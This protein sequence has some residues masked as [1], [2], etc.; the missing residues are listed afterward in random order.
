MSTQIRRSH[1][2]R[3]TRWVVWMPLVLV[4][5]LFYWTIALG[6]GGLSLLAVSAL[7]AGGR[8]ALE[9]GGTA[10]EDSAAAA[11]A[12]RDDDRSSDDRDDDDDQAEARTAGDPIQV[13]LQESV[14]PEDVN[15]NAGA[16]STPSLDPTAVEPAPGR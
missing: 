2:G 4:G 12:A 9:L 5:A 14:D 11:P 7:S 6:L 15:D 3:V 16:A 8:Q 10:S 13:H 1:G